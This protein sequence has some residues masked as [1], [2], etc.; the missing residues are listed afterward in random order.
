MVLNTYKKICVGCNKK[1][2]TSYDSQTHC[3]KYCYARW[4]IV[5]WRKKNKKRLKAQ[6][7]AKK[8]LKKTLPPIN[9]KNTHIAKWST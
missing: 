7:E 3:D 2:T 4:Y 9:K 5:R 6:R 8:A 1:F